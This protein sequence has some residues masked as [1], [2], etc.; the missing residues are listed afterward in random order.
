MPKIKAILFDMD[1][2]LIDAKEW[3]YEALNQ[4][5]SL[6]G[7]E[8]SRYDHLVTYDGLPT[9]KKL[10]M[11]TLERGLPRALHQFINDMKQEFTFQLG[12]AKCKPTFNHQYALSS[13]KASGYKI[14]AC[15]NS[16]RKTMDVLFE[17]AAIINY[18]DFYISNQDVKESKPNPEMYNE[19]MN[20]FGLKPEECLILEDNE[21]G[22][23]AAKASGGHLLIIKDVNDV[24]LE[25]ITNCIKEI[26]INL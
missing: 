22:I 6:F 26:E 17:R 14:A 23:K 11:L 21:N 16:I 9:K 20:R 18:F 8:I 13:L 1:G 4:A 2:V 12:Y 19:A 5:L 15:S 10:E 24:N 25:S 7:M 3:H